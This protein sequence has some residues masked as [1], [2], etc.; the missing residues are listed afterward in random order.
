MCASFIGHLPHQPWWQATTGVHIGSLGFHTAQSL[1]LPAFIFSPIVSRS[2]VS[3]VVGV[4]LLGHMC[5]ARRHHARVPRSHGQR[6]C[7]SGLYPTPGH[8]T[9]ALESFGR[10]SGETQHV[11]PN[12]RDGKELP[13]QH[14]D[15][16]L[17]WMTMVATNTPRSA[18]HA[19]T[20]VWIR[21]GLRTR[22]ATAR[23]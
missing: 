7:Q 12:M 16:S 6:T 19:Q 3:T 10:G 8:G 1:A 18:A 13:A 21:D 11:W 20:I 15:A 2:L 9:R 23:G 5:P 22:R 17:L 14:A 4:V